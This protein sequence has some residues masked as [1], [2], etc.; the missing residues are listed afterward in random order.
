MEGA[1]ME[2]VRTL[3]GHEARVVTEGDMLSAERTMKK[4][5]LGIIG[6]ILLAGL[7]VGES[8]ATLDSQTKANL[9]RI[10][11]VRTEGSLPIRD[12]KSDVAVIKEQQ[13]L[14]SEMLENISGRI[15]RI[16]ARK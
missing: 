13:R 8:Y 16:M 11:E 12:I 15:D 5:L 14:N 10:E 6:S 7:F 4:W 9:K 3:D 1:A 2:T